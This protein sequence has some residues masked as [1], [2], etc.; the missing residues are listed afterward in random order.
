MKTIE[1]LA[2]NGRSFLEKLNCKKC[3]GYQYNH[4]P[5]R[6][7]FRRRLVPGDKFYFLSAS[8]DE[9]RN[10]WD[11]RDYVELNGG[12][13]LSIA[14]AE[15]YEPSFDRQKNFFFTREEARRAISR[16]RGIVGRA[17]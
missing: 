13:C 16:I 6:S 11:H 4:A 15:S 10:E 12:G 9:P 3:D 5:K 7:S 17:K 14:V 8:G 2:C 1:C